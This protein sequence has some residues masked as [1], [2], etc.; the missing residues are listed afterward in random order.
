[1]R[2]VQG[3]LDYSQAPKRTQ[4][5]FLFT[6]NSYRRKDGALVMGRGAA[7]AVKEMYPG[8]NYQF[9]LQIDHLSFYGIKIVHHAAAS[10][11][12]IGVFQV[13]LHFAWNAELSIIKDSLVYLDALAVE[14][15]YSAIHMNFPGVGFG[16]LSQEEVEPLLQRLPDSVIIYR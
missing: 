6:G 1:M 16:R 14:G 12:N 2:L 11:A 4:E 3:L 8:I 13:K 15:P 5:L 7:A 10:R 9:G